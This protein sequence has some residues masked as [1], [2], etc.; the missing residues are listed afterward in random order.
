[1]L[2]LPVRVHGRDLKKHEFPVR[3]IWGTCLKSTLKNVAQTLPLYHIP[4]ELDLTNQTKNST[5]KFNG[6]E[7]D[8]LNTLG[9]WLFGLPG[10]ASNMVVESFERNI[11]LRLP[12]IPQVIELMNQTVEKLVSTLN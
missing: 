8:E 10:Y 7:F 9:G 3:N 11:C 2:V 12:Q 5:K 6:S 1:M 4:I